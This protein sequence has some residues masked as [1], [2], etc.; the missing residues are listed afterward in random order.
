MID[1]AGLSAEWVALK[2]NERLATELRRKVEDKLLSLIGFPESMEG[3]QNINH[4]TYFIKIVGR[5]THKVDSDK[6][7]DIAAVNGLTDQLTSL[8]RWKSEINSKAWN[9]APKSVTD[10]LSDAITTTPSRPSFSITLK[11]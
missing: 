9:E 3:T 11:E 10:I 8:F 5:H 6:L 4:D 1:L 7:Q 2:D